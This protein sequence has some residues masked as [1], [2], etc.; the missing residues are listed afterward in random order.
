MKIYDR[1]ENMRILFYTSAA[2]KTMR[3]KNFEQRNVKLMSVE[4]MLPSRTE[5]TGGYAE[6]T[7]PALSFMNN[8]DIGATFKK[9]ITLTRQPEIWMSTVEL[10]CD[11]FN[12]CRK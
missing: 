2:N 9:R 1:L 3:P 5:F 7:I 8:F 4:H 10:N 6:T 11:N 12:F